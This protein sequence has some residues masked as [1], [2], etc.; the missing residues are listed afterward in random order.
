MKTINGSLDQARAAVTWLDSSLASNLKGGISPSYGSW[1][2][3]TIR[4]DAV[5]SSWSVEFNPRRALIKIH[6]E[7]PEIEMMALLSI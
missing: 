4:W 7:D 5:N 6:C 2:N 1:A 3:D